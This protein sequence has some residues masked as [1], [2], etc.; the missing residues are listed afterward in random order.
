[1]ISRAHSRAPV[2]RALAP[3]FV[4]TDASPCL[5]LRVTTLTRI[6]V[7]ATV[8]RCV[9]SARFATLRTSSPAEGRAMSNRRAV[10]VVL[11]RVE[12]LEARR[13]LDGG[14][15]WWFL[16]PADDEDGSS[17]GSGY[18]DLGGIVNLADFNR[19][20]NFNPGSVWPQ[21][22]FDYNGT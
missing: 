7:A 4:A 3:P 15:G 6:D 5:L 16:P 18:A 2:S 8:F 1:M 12:S 10:R 13:L 21:G 11:G 22:D 20:A 19:L 9:A 17:A 14:E